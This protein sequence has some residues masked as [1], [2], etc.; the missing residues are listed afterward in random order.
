MDCLSTNP[1]LL[2]HEPIF[3]TSMAFFRPADRKDPSIDALSGLLSGASYRLSGDNLGSFSFMAS[4]GLSHLIWSAISGQT[5]THHFREAVNVASRNEIAQ[6]EI[7]KYVG[8]AL[9]DGLI[10][11]R[12]KLKVNITNAMLRL[13]LFPL[14]LIS[15]NHG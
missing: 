10:K 6:Y 7:R 2:D 15:R 4:S 5:F 8:I 11:A 9:D 3:E 14:S 12:S 13:K 1:E